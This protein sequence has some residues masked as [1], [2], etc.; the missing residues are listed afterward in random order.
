MHANLRLADKL[1]D[2][3]YRESTVPW[4]TDDDSDSDGNTTASGLTD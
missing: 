1:N 3:A 2:A 4:S